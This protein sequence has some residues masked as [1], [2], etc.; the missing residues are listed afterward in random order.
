MQIETRNEANRRIKELAQ[1]KTARDYVAMTA[2]QRAADAILAQ[3]V[4]EHVVL[5]TRDGV[6]HYRTTFGRVQ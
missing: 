1:A 6:S 2:A 5:W 4:V 3:S